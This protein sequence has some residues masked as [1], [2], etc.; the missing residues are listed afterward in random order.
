VSE[1]KR[2]AIAELTI[3]EARRTIGILKRLERNQ[4]RIAAEDRDRPGAPS[5]YTAAEIREAARR[6]ATRARSA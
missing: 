2:R 6:A 1:T 3:G 4:A 5:P